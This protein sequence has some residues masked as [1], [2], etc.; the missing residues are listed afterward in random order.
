MVLWVPPI[1]LAI[2]LH[3][4][5]HGYAAYL[6]GDPTAKN[7]GRLTLN[8]IPH[9]DLI[10]LIALIMFHFG[11]AK[12]VP[13]DPRYFRKP[14]RDMMLV[15]AAGPLMNLILAVASGICIKL[16]ALAAPGY[17]QSIA[18]RMLVYSMF[19][20]AILM[21]FNLIPIPPLDGSKMLYYI[22]KVPP[23]TQYQMERGG[24]MIL[25]TLILASSMLG[26]NFFGYIISP[27][28]GIFQMIFL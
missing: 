20:N 10:G 25:V 12:P 27:V 24:P 23:R 8:P 4:V 2:T 16:I 13:V 5:S 7:R 14:T 21:I 9:I 3:E 28:I 1:L 15:A 6:L 11:W 19:I 18:V 26:F 22:L 17:L